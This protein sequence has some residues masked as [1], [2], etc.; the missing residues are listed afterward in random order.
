MAGP[1]V[2]SPAGPRFVFVM[3]VVVSG[4]PGRAWNQGA[5]AVLVAGSGKHY[6]II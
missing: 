6:L 1:V 3:A 4:I 2:G 5:T